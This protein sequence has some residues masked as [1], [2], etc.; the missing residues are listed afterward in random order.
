MPMLCGPSYHINDFPPRFRVEKLMLCLSS[1]G[2]I[3]SP[4]D[5]HDTF[6]V[7]F[8][9]DGRRPERNNRLTKHCYKI[10]SL[11][12]KLLGHAANEKAES[13]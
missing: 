2:A 6:V 11:A 3:F 9:L 8:Y 1:S 13:K 5:T 12:G 7:T 4:V 10:R